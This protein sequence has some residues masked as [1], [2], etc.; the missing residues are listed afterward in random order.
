MVAGEYALQ[1]GSH[2]STSLEADAA[3]IRPIAH[4]KVME[5]GEKPLIQRLPEPHLGRDALIEP[6]E[7]LLAVGSL[8]SRRQA[9]EHFRLE[10][11]KEPAI[12]ICLGMMEFV[13]DHDIE[14]VRVQMVDRSMD[15][16]D[17]RE[18]VVPMHGPSRHR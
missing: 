18:H 15:R 3:K 12:G 2:I 1:L 9:D 16:L 8:R 4:T 6:M 10:V 7:D 17:R 5:R 13:N 14:L 11:L